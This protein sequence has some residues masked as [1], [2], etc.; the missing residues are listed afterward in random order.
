MRKKFPAAIAALVA[1]G[2]HP[3]VARDMGLFGQFVGSWSLEVTWHDGAHAGRTASGEWHFAHVLDG[4]A[5][6]DVWIVPTRAQRAEGAE[7][8][9][10]GA[11]LRFFD[12]ALSAWRS[13]WIGPTQGAV[14][15]FIARA[16]ADEIV[17][18][19]TSAEGWPM[20]W[21]F[22]QITAQSFHWRQVR[23]PD[24]GSTWR[25]FQSM[26]ARRAD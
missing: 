2:P 18:D 12:P 11:T 21:I 1:D 14:I 9:E 17:L 23:S 6:I 19:G 15:P 10:W 24:G 4:R 26:E 20:R 22:S 5:I 8:Y 7:P 3:D 25:L 13:T 16:V